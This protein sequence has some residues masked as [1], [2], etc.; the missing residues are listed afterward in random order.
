VSRSFT[1]G[2]VVGGVNGPIRMMLGLEYTICSSCASESEAILAGTF[3]PFAIVSSYEVPCA[4]ILPEVGSRTGGLIRLYHLFQGRYHK[5][6]LPLPAQMC[7]LGR[8]VIIVI[9]MS[10][11][12]EDGVAFTANHEYA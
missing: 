10:D 7:H 12:I 9:A 3:V 2:F 4:R 1:D 6:P 11:I 8:E 5:H